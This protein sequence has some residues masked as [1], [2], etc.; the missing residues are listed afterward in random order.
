MTESFDI[1]KQLQEMRKY[2]LSEGFNDSLVDSYIKSF[3]ESYDK[4]YAKV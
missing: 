4:G 2:Y 3:A 1:E